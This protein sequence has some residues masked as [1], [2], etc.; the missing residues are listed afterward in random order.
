LF[1]KTLYCG[2]SHPTITISAERLREWETMGCENVSF[3]SH[4]DHFV[5]AGQKLFEC[6]YS[7]VAKTFHRKWLEF[8]S[9]RDVH[10]SFSWNGHTRFGMEQCLASWGA[11]FHSQRCLAREIHR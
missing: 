8:G 9:P 7:N 4:V 10:A 6:I 2:S 3:L 1:D 5:A 11:E